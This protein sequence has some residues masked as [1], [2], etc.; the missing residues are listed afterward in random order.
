VRDERWGM[1]EQVR[2]VILVT[3][4]A[5]LLA[6]C[7][8]QPATYEI[9]IGSLTIRVPVYEDPKIIQDDIMAHLRPLWDG[10]S[11]GT[12][13]SFQLK[14]NAT[15]DT[16][17]AKAASS[18]PQVAATSTT[19]SPL[20]RFFKADDG[21]GGIEQLEEGKDPLK[22]LSLH[23]PGWAEIEKYLRQHVI[24]LD[25]IRVLVQGDFSQNPGK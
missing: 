22:M 10:L 6:G 15:F 17:A 19:S 12:S 18:G 23:S 9:V 24:T 16:R 3:V 14:R 21:T 25:Y 4:L 7:G 2:N 11:T 1:R 20:R 8:K 13:V 5:M